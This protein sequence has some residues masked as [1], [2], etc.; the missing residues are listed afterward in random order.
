[1]DI[2]YSNAN[3]AD[4]PKEDAATTSKKAPKKTE[5][6]AKREMKE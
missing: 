6:K 1:M 5:A 3:M 4:A 2:S